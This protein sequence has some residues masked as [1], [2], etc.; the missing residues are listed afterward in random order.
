MWA[1]QPCDLRNTVS[2]LCWLSFWIPK[3]T[4]R[5]TWLKNQASGY[6]FLERSDPCHSSL[7]IRWETLP[8]PSQAA[9]KCLFLLSRKVPPS[10]A[11]PKGHV[12]Y[13]I[14]SSGENHS[15]PVV[16]ERVKFKAATLN[17]VV[18]LHVSTDLNILKIPRRSQAFAVPY[19]KVKMSWVAMV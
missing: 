6:P 17:P 7:K 14:C 11:R 3:V 10:H 13:W 1:R 4:P 9:S 8:V 16:D 2:E 15:P 5:F 19:L 18:L 12:L